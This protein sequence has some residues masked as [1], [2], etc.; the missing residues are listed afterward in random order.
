MIHVSATQIY[1]L[2]VLLLTCIVVLQSIGYVGLARFLLT[3][4]SLTAVILLAAHFAGKGLDKL[5]HWWLLAEDERNKIFCSAATRLRRSIRFSVMP[6][7]ISP[8]WW[9]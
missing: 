2:F 1:P 7:V 5:L 8:I 9:R 4:S 6:L 3:S